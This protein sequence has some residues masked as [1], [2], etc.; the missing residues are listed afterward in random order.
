[1]FSFLFLC[2]MWYYPLCIFVYRSVALLIGHFAFVNRPSFKFQPILNLVLRFLGKQ[3][4]FVS[5]E[6][7]YIDA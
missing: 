3:D 1:M 5:L 4:F 6:S 2:P 7:V